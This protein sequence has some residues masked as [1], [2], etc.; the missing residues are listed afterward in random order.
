M[1]FRHVNAKVLLALRDEGRPVLGGGVLVRAEEA[2][3]LDA[4]LLERSVDVD[5]FLSKPSDAAAGDVQPDG[6]TIAHN[7]KRFG[8][9]VQWTFPLL[10][11][12]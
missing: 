3:P 7:F 10:S 2:L 11:R 5:P 8:G 1:F 12:S 9:E 4:L 6:D